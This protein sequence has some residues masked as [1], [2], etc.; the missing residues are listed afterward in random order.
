MNS[1]NEIT[2]V[3]RETA[4]FFHTCQPSLCASPC[5]SSFRCV[6]LPVCRP[7]QCHPNPECHPPTVSRP[8]PVTLI[9]GKSVLNYHTLRFCSILCALSFSGGRGSETGERGDTEHQVTARVE[10]SP[11]QG[12]VHGLVNGQETRGQLF[13]GEAHYPLWRHSFTLSIRGRTQPCPL[14]GN[15]PSGVAA[16]LHSSSMPGAHV[17]L[18]R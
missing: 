5:S 4:F 8:S 1:G 3:F 17:T 2:F 13:S 16:T 15:S 12:V 11:G 6:T 14:A 18:V 10:G 7:K 9:A